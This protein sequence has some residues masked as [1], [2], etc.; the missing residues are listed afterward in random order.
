[1]CCIQE[2][3]LWLSYFGSYFLLFCLKY[4]LCPLC[5]SNTLLNILMVLGRNVEQ[6][7]MM[8][9]IQEWQLW[10]SYFWCYL[11]VIFDSDYALI[12]CQLC[13][14]NTF[15]IFLWYLVKNVAEDVMTCWVQEW[16]LWLTY[17]WSYLPF[18]YLNLI[19][20]P[21]CNSSTLHNILMIL[22][23]NVEQDDTTYHLQEWQLWWG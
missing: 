17:F 18:L 7:E 3:Q 15:G 10:L 13:K 23:R 5:Y 20:C 9:R 14:L 19:S 12:S 6:D 4:N 21:Y 2:W 11:F 22:G 8:W 1:M 16:Q